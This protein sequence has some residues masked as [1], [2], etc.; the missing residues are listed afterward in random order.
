[1]EMTIKFTSDDLL[2]MCR[3]RVAGMEPA[4]GTFGVRRGLYGLFEIVAE[5]IP[6]T[7]EPE[8]Q[9]MVLHVEEAPRGA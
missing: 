1:M 2:D 3:K 7:D 8:A 9:P 4:P 6:A 5:F